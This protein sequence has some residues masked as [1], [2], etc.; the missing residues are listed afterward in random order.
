MAL[1]EYLLFVLRHPDCDVNVLARW[2]WRY[3]P[4]EDEL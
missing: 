3:E 4:I 2:F 1:G